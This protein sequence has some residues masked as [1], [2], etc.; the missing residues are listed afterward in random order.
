MSPDGFLSSRLLFF[1]T[2]TFYLNN[3]YTVPKLFKS[4]GY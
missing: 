2:R 4:F 1:P 3:K